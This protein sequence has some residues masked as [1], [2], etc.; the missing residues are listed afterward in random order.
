MMARRA[1]WR[2]SMSSDRM[3]YL[4]EDGGKL[5]KD[6]APH[7]LG[8]AVPDALGSDEHASTP[9]FSVR[10]I[11]SRMASMAGQ[12]GKA[13]TIDLGAKFSTQPVENRPQA[14]KMRRNVG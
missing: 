14:T 11:S 7:R 8:E 12:S 13:P 5:V 4:R 1:K 2:S 10:V 3:C 6:V 9:L